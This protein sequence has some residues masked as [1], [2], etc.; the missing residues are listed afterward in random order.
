MGCVQS[1][2][3]KHRINQ[4][5]HN[6]KRQPQRRSVS[7]SNTAT[8]PVLTSH[9]IN[10]GSEVKRSAFPATN[11]TH[12][13]EGDC[14]DIKEKSSSS[15]IED[16]H[17]RRQS[18]D[19]NS[20]LRQ[21]KKR[22]R[23]NST[24]S[25]NTSTTTAN[26][27]V[28][29]SPRKSKWATETIDV[30]VPVSTVTVANTA[31]L[32]ASLDPQPSES[33]WKNH[34]NL[35]SD[36]R[37]QQTQS[38]RNGHVSTEE[39]RAT[40]VTTPESHEASEPPQRGDFSSASANVAALLGIKSQPQVNSEQPPT[41][42]TSEE[43][44]LSHSALPSFHIGDYAHSALPPQTTA[45]PMTTFESIQTTAAARSSNS[46]GF[47]MMSASEVEKRDMIKKITAASVTTGPT[48]ATVAAIRSRRSSAPLAPVASNSTDHRNRKNRK[49]SVPNP[50]APPP[51]ASSTG[52]SSATPTA[53][54]TASSSLR[55]RREAAAAVEREKVLREKEAHVEEEELE[56][57][58][59]LI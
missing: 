50:P 31:P 6:N 30:N 37:Q 23:K 5:H 39:V 45:A 13:I 25:A 36:H 34:I 8:P 52:I 26:G 57:C 4:P 28:T 9:H 15:G 48:T 44:W 41:V 58:G 1:H 35:P 43:Q 27:S 22:T 56:D 14:N 20:V 19:R 49:T 12:K 40:S 55:T 2:E 46:N 11:Q 16:V 7:G 18:F 17:F 51:R 47:S 54:A 10:G 3:N 24:A 38:T 53:S 29:T 33:V 21:S 42:Q 59:R 32:E